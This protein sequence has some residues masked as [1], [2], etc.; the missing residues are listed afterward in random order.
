MRALDWLENQ[1]LYPKVYW[2]SRD[3]NRIFAGAGAA[4]ILSHLPGVSM[5]PS[6]SYFFGGMSFSREACK[7]PWEGFPKQFFFSPKKLLIENNQTTEQ[8]DFPP[9]SPIERANCP[10]EAHWEEIVTHYLD[11][12]RQGELEKIVAARCASYRCASRIQPLQ[13][14]RS[15]PQQ[16]TTLFALLLSED[17]A[18]LAATPELLYKRTNRSISSEALAG[19]RKRGQTAEE[20][21]RLEQ[22]LLGSPKE[23]REFLFVKH[24]IQD[25]LHPLCNQ[26]TSEKPSILKTASVQ[27]LYSKFQAELKPGITDQI[28][29]DALHPT[30]AMGGLPRKQALE[31]LK[32][33][34]PF[35]RGWYAAPIGWLSQ[36]AAE[37]AVGIRS[38]LIQSDQIHLFSGTGI[39]PG[40]TPSSEWE[41]LEH[42]IRPFAL[43]L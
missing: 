4:H 3:T 12:I 37:I 13:L 14:L 1:E 25:A 18:F 22:E 7:A 23:Q 40:S 43:S 15:L 41:E 30:P 2:Q 29:I 9:L 34:E 31:I 28:L 26:V 6:D 17:V 36:S 35:D 24:F 10:T 20:D 19:T 39:V 32:K 11:K 21:L 27:H 5:L 38:A 42:K 16:R 33:H 8:R